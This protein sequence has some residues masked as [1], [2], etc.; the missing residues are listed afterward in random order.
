MRVSSIEVIVFEKLGEEVIAVN[1]LAELSSRIGRPVA[2][3]TEEVNF[4]NSS[5]RR[6]SGLSVAR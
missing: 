5:T 1:K 6:K 3:S 4:L 2:F